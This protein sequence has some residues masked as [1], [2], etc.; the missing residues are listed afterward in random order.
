[1]YIDIPVGD[2]MGDGDNG[3]FDALRAAIQRICYDRS[4]VISSTP[5]ASGAV[6]LVGLELAIL[7]RSIRSWRGKSRY[8]ETTYKTVKLAYGKVWQVQIRTL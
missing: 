8:G 2:D 5:I 7:D 6:R 1:M 3:L 4:C